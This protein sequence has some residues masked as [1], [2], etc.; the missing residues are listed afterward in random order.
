[1]SNPNRPYTKLDSEQALKQSFSEANDA[2]RT[3]NAGGTLVPEKF[4]RTVL[5]YVVAGNGTGEIQTVTY[6]DGVEQ[7]ATLTLMYDGQN[8][9]VDV[10]RS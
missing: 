10:T 2:L 9:L 7:V 4:T 8:R 1:M 5:T 6:F 3:L